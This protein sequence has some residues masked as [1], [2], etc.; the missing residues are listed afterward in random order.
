MG[1]VGIVAKTAANTINK[2]PNSLRSL[3]S[4]APRATEEATAN[5]ISESIT[6][7]DVAAD[8]RAMPYCKLRLEASMHSATPST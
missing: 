1:R 3:N 4:A 8:M 2:P 6:S 7:E 5:T